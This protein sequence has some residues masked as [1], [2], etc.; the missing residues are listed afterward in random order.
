MRKLAAQ[1]ILLS[2]IP[3]YLNNCLVI[4]IVIGIPIATHAQSYG[5]PLAGLPESTLVS[6]GNCGSTQPASEIERKIPQLVNSARWRE[7]ETVG[8]QLVR[9]CPDSD[10]GYHWVG[11]SYLRQGRSFAAIRAFEDSLR[12]REDAGAHLLLAEAYYE[13]GQKQFFWEEIDA[14]KKKAPQESGI[15]YLAGLFCFQTEQANEKA[16]EWFHMALDR[17]PKHLLARCHLALCLQAM[18]QYEE[19]ES[20]LLATVGDVSG[21]SAQALPA[22]QLLVSL[23]IEMNQPADALSHARLAAQIAPNS[24]KV[25][26]ALGK[27]ALATHDQLTA[28][29]AFK[30]A[31]ALDP[32]SPEPHYLLSRVY[33]AQ[34]QDQMA[35]QEIT[36]FKRL[37][38]LYHGSFE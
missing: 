24:A 21:T 6:G 11:V 32:E 35:Q 2:K 1:K 12:K 37:R 33:T 7:L 9:A 17:N 30:A 22:L 19:A 10:I 36:T 27:A 38:Q 23:E 25:Q 29:A 28:L 26:L 31:G 18:Q 8:D 20:T 14:A 16:A 13:L 34:G 5:R 15:Y 3:H 4:G